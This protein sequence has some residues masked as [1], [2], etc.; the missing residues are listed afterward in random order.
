MIETPALCVED[1]TS[2]ANT[3]LS[4]KN[5]VLIIEGDKPLALF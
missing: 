5:G 1:P 3:L 2:F 4:S